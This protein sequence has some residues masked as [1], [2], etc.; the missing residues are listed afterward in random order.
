MQFPALPQT[1]LPR[2]SRASGATEF[3]A[4]LFSRA[5]SRT[6]SATFL[7]SGE[8]RPGGFRGPRFVPARAS[9]ARNAVDSAR[10]P[11]ALAQAASVHVNVLTGLTGLCVEFALAARPRLAKVASR[12]P[13]GSTA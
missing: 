5:I 11:H 12:R 2:T 7:T 13:V 1:K 9:V 8:R 4:L 10:A 3:R 6:A